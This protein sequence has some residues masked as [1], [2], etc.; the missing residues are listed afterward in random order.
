[1]TDCNKTLNSNFTVLNVTL[2]IKT[3]SNENNTAF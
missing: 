1:M 2:T 3:M